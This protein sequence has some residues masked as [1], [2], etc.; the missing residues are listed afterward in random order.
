MVTL[1][2]L[3]VV[4]KN[5]DPRYYVCQPVLELVN[6]AGNRLGNLP[7]NDIGECCP[8]E[9]YARAYKLNGLHAGDGT[10]ARPCCQFLQRPLAG[11]PLFIGFLGHA[12]SAAP[13]RLPY[14]ARSRRCQPSNK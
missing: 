4:S 6:R 11:A 9:S 13:P 2:G 12:G 14:L 8:G 7:E 10:N 3:I 1:A 5:T